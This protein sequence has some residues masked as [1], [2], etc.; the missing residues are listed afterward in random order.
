MNFGEMKDYLRSIVNDKSLKV[1][2]GR[3]LNRTIFQIAAD[4]ELPDLKII[5]PVPLSVDNSKWFW[6]LPD[7]FHKKLYQ[8]R[9]ST[10]AHWRHVHI[11]DHIEELNRHDASHTRTGPHVE[12]VAVADQGIPGQGQVSFLG[13]HPLPLQMEVLQLWFYRKPTLLTKEGDFCDCIPPEFIQRVV[14]PKCIVMNF[15]AFTDGIE[16]GP[17]KSLEYWRNEYKI[18]LS[19]EAYGDLGLKDY[20]A[21]RRG[22]P[23]RTG[24]R[25]PIGAR[26]RYGNL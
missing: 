21:K 14:I 16:D 6:Q 15:Q 12:R 17:M 18:G 25:D 13:I 20:I 22:G 10:Y 2:F 19:G 3:Q 4:L 8:V 24:G 5:T 9:D 1:D 7:A 23:R 11:C 26:S